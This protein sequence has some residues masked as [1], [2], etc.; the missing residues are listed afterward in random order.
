MYKQS[1]TC[2]CIL[3]KFALCLEIHNVYTSII[4]MYIFSSV[5]LRLPE[6]GRTHFDCVCAGCVAWF[7]VCAYPQDPLKESD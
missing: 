4:S 3:S 2:R 7:L 1:C 5:K 6:N